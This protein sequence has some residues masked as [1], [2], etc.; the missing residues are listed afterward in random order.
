MGGG[1]GA[2]VTI[3]QLAADPHSTLARLRAAAPVCWVPALRGWLVTSHAAVLRVLRDSITFTVD[4][5]RFSTARV[6]G[7]SMLSLDG[8]EHARHR[9]PFARA[10]RPGDVR[11]RFT[12]LVE[13]ESDRLL[14]ALRPAGRAD[15]RADLAGPLSVRVMA[16]ALGVDRADIEAARRWYAALV[17]AVE[18]MS[19]GRAVPTR[20]VAAFDEL[21][22]HVRGNIAAG[23]LLADAAGSLDGAEL[24]ANAAV[25]M[26]GGIDT[27]EAM[28]TN[29]VLH[30]LDNPDQLALVRAE[31]DRLLDAIEESM[32]LEPAAAS[33]DRYATRDVTVAEADIAAGDLVVVSIA[34]ANRDPAV[35]EHPDRFD[36]D[37]A[38]SDRHLAFAQGPH[39]CIGAHLARL[40]TR[41]A[42]TGLLARF[43]R[44]RL[45][46][47]QAPSPQGLIFRRPASLPV[48]W[49]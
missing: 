6:V 35:F 46:S 3:A 19:A 21:R 27:T 4:D 16:A 44:L 14:D 13:E 12:A 45:R 36:T 24:V 10:F 31:P 32:R 47:G 33:L 2:P 15:L 29:T 34:G 18:D 37:R 38:N 9:D 30:L 40:E 28:I 22:E 39:F 17:Q 25:L 48:E 20:A 1:P 5:P 26:F 8:A 23:S 41:T 49:N 7:P 43:P 42:L 11:A